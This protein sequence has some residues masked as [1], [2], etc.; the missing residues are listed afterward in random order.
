MVQVGYFGSQGNALVNLNDTNYV[1]SLGPGSINSRRRFTSIFVPTSAPAIAGPVQGV[2]ISPLGSILRQEYSGNTNFNAMQTNLTHQISHG[3][4]ILATWVW[5]K[6][7]G[8]TFDASPQGSSA[9]YSY[10][11]SREYSRGVR[12]IGHAAC[13]V[14]SVQRNLGAALRTR[15]AIRIK[16]CSLGKRRVGRLESGRNRSAT[17]GRPFT[18]TVNGN[19]SNSGQ[20]DRANIVGNPNSVPGGRTKAEFYQ[21]CG[22]CGQRTVHVRQ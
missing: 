18:V 3:F 12:S 15:K 19:P 7:L 13:T 11:E 14:V 20:T 8:D 5:S 16:S 1:T 6:A 22:V 4:T 2:T 9:G 10:P 17:S 21:Y